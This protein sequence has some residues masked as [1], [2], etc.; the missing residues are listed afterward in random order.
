L[1]KNSPQLTTQYNIGTKLPKDGGK[2]IRKEKHIPGAVKGHTKKM[3]FVEQDEEGN[4]KTVW[5]DVSAGISHKD[6]NTGEA[7]PAEGVSLRSIP[8]GKSSKPAPP[9]KV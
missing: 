8:K 2:K 1:D 9:E 3:K 6:S 4:E 7:V 5:K